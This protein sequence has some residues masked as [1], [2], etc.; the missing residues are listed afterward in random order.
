LGQ[1]W[2]FKD[3]IRDYNLPATLF[4]RVYGFFIS[5]EGD[6]IPPEVTRWAVKKAKLNR[7]KRGLDKI[8]F[9]SFWNGLDEWMRVYKPELLPQ[10]GAL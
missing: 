6:K 7:D 4:A 1:S 8:T 5:M 3:W 10:A 9:T 2:Q